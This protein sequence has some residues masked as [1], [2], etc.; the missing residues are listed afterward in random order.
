MLSKNLTKVI[1]AD[2]KLKNGPQQ[3]IIKNYGKEFD[4][5]GVEFKT[6]DTFSIVNS[7]IN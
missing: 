6:E 7:M 2:E 3:S 1:F 5:E 4:A